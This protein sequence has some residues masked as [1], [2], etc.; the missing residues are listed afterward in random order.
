MSIE[1]QHDLAASASPFAAALAQFTS[2]GWAVHRSTVGRRELA[3]VIATMGVL[4]VGEPG[5]QTRALHTRAA[6]VCAALPAT[7]RRHVQVLDPGADLQALAL[8][9]VLTGEDAERVGAALS[10]ANEVEALTV[11]EVLEWSRH[12]QPEPTRPARTSRLQRPAA[13]LSRHAI[14]FAVI[15]LGVAMLSVVGLGNG[16]GEGQ[17]AEARS[18]VAT[19]K[20]QH[21]G[22]SATP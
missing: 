11:A 6:Q 14:L 2:R 10:A 4:V 16:P 22:D 3:V 8:P 15:A 21:T 1:P 19:T 7:L 13:W 5:L 20:V 9:A 17:G 12:S 18:A